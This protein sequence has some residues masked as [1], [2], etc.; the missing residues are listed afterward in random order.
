LTLYPVSG[1]ILFDS[2]LAGH[3]DTGSSFI[4]LLVYLYLFEESVLIFLHAISKMEY[5]D[6]F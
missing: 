5:K 3:R 2:T 4:F 6:I 1:C